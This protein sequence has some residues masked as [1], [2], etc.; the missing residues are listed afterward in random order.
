MFQTALPA[1][2]NKRTAYQTASTIDIAPKYRLP[3]IRLQPKT[4]A[5]FLQARKHF[6]APLEPHQL[7]TYNLCIWELRCQP[8]AAAAEAASNI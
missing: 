6:K 2:S 4:D 1:T 7:R 8:P 3:T 5:T